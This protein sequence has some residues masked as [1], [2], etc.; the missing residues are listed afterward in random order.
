[1]RVFN[2]V[3]S[4][5]ALFAILAFAA[6]AAAQSQ[7]AAPIGLTPQQVHDFIVSLG[8]DADPVVTEGEETGF[9]VRDGG[10]LWGVLF[11]NC[12]QGVCGSLQFT[13]NFTDPSITPEL[14]NRWNRERR[15]LKAFSQ[16]DAQG[17][18][19]AVVQY[20]V[21]LDDRPVDQLVDPLVVW[22]DMLQEFGVHVGFLEPSTGN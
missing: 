18:L 10:M 8:G 14:I 2:R 20:D 12:T 9:I 3:P 11:Y 15:F 22:I 16:T 7:T 13:A 4:L 5:L 19:Q 1:M 6:P 21:L 17:A